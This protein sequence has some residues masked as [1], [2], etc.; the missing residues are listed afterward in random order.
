MPC[1]RIA[2]ANTA[3]GSS[4][5][6]GTG[7]YVIW[8]SDGA[9]GNV[10]GKQVRMHNYHSRCGIGIFEVAVI[11]TGYCSPVVGSRGERRR[12]VSK[13]RCPADRVP[14]YIV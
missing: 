13:T 3:G 12:I 4:R 11:I 9:G 5:I 10:A 14:V 7:C 1:I 6:D 2:A 8:Y